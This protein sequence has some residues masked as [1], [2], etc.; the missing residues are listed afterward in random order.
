[1]VVEEVEDFYTNAVGE[2]KVGNV[3][4]PAL[5]GHFGFEADVGA[6]WLLLGLW[7]NQARVGDDAADGG[8]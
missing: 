4:L 3:G 5:I 2:E 8:S 6:S 7:G 1:M